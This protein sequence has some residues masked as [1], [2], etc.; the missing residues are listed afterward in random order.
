MVLILG[1]LTGF[2]GLSHGLANR[3][4]SEHL[5]SR[6]AVIALAPLD[7]RAVV[8]WPGGRLE[9]VQQGE[10]IPGTTA[11]VV[12]VLPDRLVVSQTTT[13]T[14]EVLAWMYQASPAGGFSRI[15]YLQR[16]TAP[17]ERVST[18]SSIISNP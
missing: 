4:E 17:P 9:V 15:V 10:P 18:S 13:S 8:K 1:L 11:I 6:L 5:L 3:L 2:A 14:G 7:G 12:Q 16:A